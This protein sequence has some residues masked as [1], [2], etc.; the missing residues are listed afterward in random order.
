MIHICYM[1]I[2]IICIILKSLLFQKT[3]MQLTTLFQSSRMSRTQKASC[4][5]PS[6]K[7]SIR[8]WWGKFS[9]L[10]APNIRLLMQNRPQLPLQLRS[11]HELI[12]VFVLNTIVT[13]IYQN[14]I[15]GLATIFA[16]IWFVW[17]TVMLLARK[18]A[19]DL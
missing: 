11:N 16:F 5:Y 1:L 12:K 4:A 7:L 9:L 6:W 15:V 8:R 13:A 2:Y 18:A 10:S 14:K 19:A 17:Q 3:A